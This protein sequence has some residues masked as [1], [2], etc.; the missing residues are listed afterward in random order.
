MFF[1]IYILTIICGLGLLFTD[2]WFAGALILI[3]FISIPI[4]GISF[5]KKWKKNLEVESKSL[6]F[7]FKSLEK[8]KTNFRLINSVC[9][10]LTTFKMLLKKLSLLLDDINIKRGGTSHQHY[11]HTNTVDQMRDD[12]YRYNSCYSGYSFNIHHRSK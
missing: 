9:G 3:W 10:E 6:S 2:L 5:Y 4:R 1:R 8:Q 11:S 7:G 12:D